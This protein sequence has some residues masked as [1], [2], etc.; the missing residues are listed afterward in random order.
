MRY[1]SWHNFSLEYCIWVF[2]VAL[3]FRCFKDKPEDKSNNVLQE[4]LEDSLVNVDW[5]ENNEN[6]LEAGVGELGDM[7]S[8]RNEKKESESEDEVSKIYIFYWWIE[9]A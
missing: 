6:K 7:L 1:S 5:A 9:E 3:I 2:Y 8:T 4:V